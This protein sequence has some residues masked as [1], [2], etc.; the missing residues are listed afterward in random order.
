MQSLVFGGQECG[1]ISLLHASGL[2][3]P[4]PCPAHAGHVIKLTSPT[5]RIDLTSSNPALV[6]YG[7]DNML[8]IWGLEVTKR[9][10]NVVLKIRASIS[11][12]LCPTHMGLLHSTLCLALSDNKIVQL[13]FPPNSRYECLSLDTLPLLTHQPE[14]DHTEEI[15]SL[16][17]CTRLKLFATSS[18][19]GY[20]KV[21]GTDNHLVSEIHFGASLASVGFANPLGDLLVGFQKHICI[22]EAGNYLPA[23]LVTEHPHCDHDS[24]EEPITFDPELEFWCVKLY[25]HNTCVSYHLM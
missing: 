23:E 22:V 19:D 18:S 5:D 16:S 24:V 6:S 13:D 4:H 1:H 12:K 15:T 2:S 14:D 9:T 3:M 17:S 10:Q 8:S 21:W 7:S 25:C 11:L 20:V